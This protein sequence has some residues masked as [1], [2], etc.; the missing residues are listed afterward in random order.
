MH[1]CHSG[2]D[3]KG[4]YKPG[5]MMGVWIHPSLILPSMISYALPTPAARTEAPP[6][7]PVAAAQVVIDGP[8]DKPVPLS[9]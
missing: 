6:P 9:T 1:F 3:I 4:N 8:G 5:E 7:I 2:E